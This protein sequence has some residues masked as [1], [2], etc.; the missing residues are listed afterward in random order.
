MEDTNLVTCDQCNKQWNKEKLDRY[1]S[2][3]FGCTGCEQYVCPY[4]DNV[5]VVKPVRKMKTNNN[6]D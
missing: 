4:C 2:N 5:I 1:C 3:C 6:E